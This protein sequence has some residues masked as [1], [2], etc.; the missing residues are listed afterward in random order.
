MEFFIW[1]FLLVVVVC[2]LLILSLLLIHKKE[3]KQKETKE[4]MQLKQEF[5]QMQMDLQKQ[6]HH[7]LEQ[8]HTSNYQQMML[9]E[10]KMKENLLYGQTHTSQTF[11]KVME[12]MGRIDEAQTQLKEMS[13]SLQTLQ[14]VFV[15]K[16]SRGTYGEIEL[17]ALLDYQMQGNYRLLQKQHKLSNGMIADACLLQLDGM[18]KLCIDS[19]FPLENYRRMC[20]S[21]TKEEEK[22]YHTAFI[23]DVKKHIKT[24]AQ[25]YI[26]EEETL[27]FAFLF[28]P[29]ETIFSYIHTSCEEVV[30]TSFEQCVYLVSPSTL[31]ASVTL[32][33]AMNLHMQRNQNARTI[34]KEL[35]LLQKEF[36][37]FHQ[38]YERI[39]SDFEKTYHDF[40]QLDITA[41]KMQRRF[42][43]IANV[44]WEEKEK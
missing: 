4:A 20:N 16:K 14:Q 28:L 15:D 43:E 29:S 42:E 1:I 37:H 5:M 2:L 9:M 18:N 41:R 17:Y 8:M 31:M 21:K 12:Q 6:L 22:K 40:Q 38:R 34:H 35:L 36:E 24:I 23:N 39:R 32:V 7:D 3:K 19:K 25:K 33:K 11:E 30:Q 27:P 10:Q 13:S 44:T 26:L